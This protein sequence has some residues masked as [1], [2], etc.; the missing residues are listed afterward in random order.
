MLPRDDSNGLEL[1]EAISGELN[2]YLHMASKEKAAAGKAAAAVAKKTLWKNFFKYY[3][4][5]YKV[6]STR[7]SQS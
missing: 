6:A 3:L 4:E 1:I 5:A 2:D 7:H